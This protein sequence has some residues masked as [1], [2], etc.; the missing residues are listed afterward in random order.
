MD[1]TQRIRAILSFVRAADAGS[2]AAAARSL[3]ISS[4]A[5]SKNV[6]GLER[7]LGVRLMNRTTRTLTLTSEGTAFLSQ[8]RV[9]LAAL[10]AAV[11]SVAARQVEP[12]G[13]V[14]IS[15]SAAFGRDQLM[16]ALPGLLA[17]H[18]TLSFEVDFDDR[19]IDL[20]QE[21]YDLALR[22][23]QI[24]DSSLVSRPICRLN[25]ALVA[26]P[27]YL[28]RQGVPR[29]AS[30]LGEH[31][32]LARRFLGGRV[33]AWGFRGPEGSIESFEPESAV[34]TVSAPEALVQAALSGL[35]IAQAGVHHVWPHLQAG[36]LKVILG[37]SHDPGSYEMTLQYPHRALLAPRVRATIE[38]LLDVFAR[39]E[40]LHVPLGALR[41]YWA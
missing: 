33:S 10:D 17:R 40:A 14:R 6:A 25:M 20:V 32:L 41:A 5:V 1:S 29:T 30:D 39:D 24:V 13:R 37:E 9:A 34:V 23:G 3:D 19:R 21:G 31:Q 4:A 35:G 2:F 26:A 15:T 38:Y 22:G 16:P 18:P 12:S 7:A 11:D 27:A 8:A 28:E 36:T